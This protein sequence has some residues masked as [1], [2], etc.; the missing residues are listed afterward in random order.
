MIL[1]DTSACIDLAQ[2]PQHVAGI[3]VP[4]DIR[5]KGNGKLVDCSLDQLRENCL[6]AFEV[7]I[8]RSFGQAGSVCNGFGGGGAVPLLDKEDLGRVEQLISSFFRGELGALLYSQ[9]L[10]SFCRLHNIPTGKYL[11]TYN[12]PCQGKFPGNLLEPLFLSEKEHQP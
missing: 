3:E 6:L 11:N 2:K 12:I 4:I 9:R 5:R 1:L 8:E 10:L 7:E